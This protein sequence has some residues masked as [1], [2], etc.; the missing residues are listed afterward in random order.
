[1][2]VSPERYMMLAVSIILPLVVLYMLAQA[3]TGMTERV[4]DSLTPTSPTS[5]VTE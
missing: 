4:S 1:M 3:V 5:V 2:N